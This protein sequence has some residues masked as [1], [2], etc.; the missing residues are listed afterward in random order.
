VTYS[1]QMIREIEETMNLDAVPRTITRR[2]GVIVERGDIRLLP[3]HVPG[4]SSSRGAM[5]L[6]QNTSIYMTVPVTIL[7]ETVDGDYYYI[8]SPVARGWISAK[9]V[10]V[11]TKAGIRPLV[12]TDS[13]L[14]ATGNKVPVYG[15]S[16]CTSFRQYLYFSGR[17]PFVRKTDK[18]YVVKLPERR[19]DG[20]LGVIEGFLKPDADVHIG[21]LPYTKRNVVTQV[22]KLLHQPYGWA[23]RLKNRDCSGTMRVLFRCFGF[24]MGRWPN[25]LLLAPPDK[26]IRY[27]D[28]SLSEEEKLAE[29]A[30]SEALITVAGSGGHV[31]LWL[32]RAANGKYYFMHEAGWGYN[33]GDQHYY[34]NQVNINEATH[35][36]FNIKS[37]PVFS[38]IRD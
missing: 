34:V 19:Q 1:E 31:T 15:D 37:A 5:D 7:H 29:A 12:A 14:M 13:I 16:E 23:D 33:E 35:S 36:W 20:S 28:S 11:G 10:A 30:K 4:F 18:A 27:I 6:F 22:F 25:F 3:T 26:Y 2:Y 8:E 17:V 32:G 24:T 38:T 21:F 9:T